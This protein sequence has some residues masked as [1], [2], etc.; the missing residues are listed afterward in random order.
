MS[1]IPEFAPK[2]GTSSGRLSKLL[3]IVDL[4][5]HNEEVTGADKTL[6]VV[7]DSGSAAQH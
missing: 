7:V 4:D 3:G 6:E 5:L 1:Q 2:L